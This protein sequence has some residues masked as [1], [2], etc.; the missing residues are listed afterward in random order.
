MLS[1]LLIASHCL[2]RLLTVSYVSLT[3]NIQSDRQIP[4]AHTF[5][6]CPTLFKNVT[7]FLTYNSYLQYATKALDSL[8]THFYY[9]FHTL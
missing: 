1:S 7:S 2:S 5:I 8:G 6:M 9:A 3:L 4:Q